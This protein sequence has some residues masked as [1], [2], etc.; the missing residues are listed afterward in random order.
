M[1]RTCSLIRFLWLTLV[2]LL[3]PAPSGRIPLPAHPACSSCLLLLLPAHPVSSCCVIVLPDHPVSSCC[4]LILGAGASGML[5][6]TR[7]PSCKTWLQ[8]SH[9]RL[10]PHSSVCSKYRAS[11]RGP[12]LPLNRNATFPILF[13][14]MLHCSL[15]V[16]CAMDS[17]SAFAQSLTSLHLQISYS[18]LPLLVLP[19][20]SLHRLRSC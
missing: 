13:Q 1:L 3:L 10:F 5:A 7:R 15:D 11:C 9:P 19:M 2:L 18:Q 14:L 8:W 17:T 12:I 20:M 16:P 4:L 6:Q